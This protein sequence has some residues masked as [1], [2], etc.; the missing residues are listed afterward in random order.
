MYK[1]GHYGLNSLLYAPIAVIIATISSIELALLGAVFFVG[2]SSIPD[3]DRHFDKNMNSHRSDVWHLVPIKHRGFT[4]TVWFA[5]LFGALSGVG[6]IIMAPMAASQPME[7]VAIFGVVCGFGGIIG[8]ILGDAITPMGVK[9][10]SPIKRKK[11]SLGWFNASNSVAN[12]GFLL[13]GGTALLVALSYGVS[14]VGFDLDS[15]T[16]FISG[17]WLAFT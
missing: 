3:V 15:V 6:A 9:P 1:E 17:I 14:E 13:I 5:A 4:H 2:A 16:G 8:H 11:Y 10:F 12:Y 7:I